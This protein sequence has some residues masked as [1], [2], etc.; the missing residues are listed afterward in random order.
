MI[1]LSRLGGTRRTDIM[2]M[3]P[4]AFLGDSNTARIDWNAELGRH[5]CLQHGRNGDTTSGIFQRVKS[6][7]DTGTRIAIINGGKNDAAAEI[8]PETLAANLLNT[9]DRKTDMEGKREN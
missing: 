2:H 4:I 3:T 6:V 8:P 9:A 5:D 1:G 7:I